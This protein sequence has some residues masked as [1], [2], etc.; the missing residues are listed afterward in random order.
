M[1]QGVKTDSATVELIK[2]LHG[3]GLSDVQIANQL[4][5]KRQAVNVYRAKMGLASLGRCQFSNSDKSEIKRLHAMG[6]HDAEIAKQMKRNYTS[7]N[8]CRISLGLPLNERNLI[9]EETAHKIASQ[10]LLGSPLAELASQHGVHY[11]VVLYSWKKYGIKSR[12]R[13]SLYH[14]YDKNFLDEINNESAYWLGFIMADGCNS[15]VVGLQVA[16]SGRD[17]EHLEKLKSF[18]KFSGPVYDYT[19]K[20][21]PVAK[22]QL[23]GQKFSEVLSKWGIVPRKSRVATAHNDLASNRHF[24]RGVVDGD[25]HINL[26]YTVLE[27]VGSENLM[28]QFADYVLSVI[29]FRPNVHA[30]KS[31]FRVRVY[32]KKAKR[33]VHHLYGNCEHYLNRKMDAAR[34]M[35]TNVVQDNMRHAII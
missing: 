2:K 23:G 19:V 32:S 35:L 18:A 8:G 5:L 20:G 11:T 34:S 24:W 31:I 28:N 14:S 10:H 9:Q 33:M 25:G 7:V 15:P 27:L 13:Q 16:L 4:G 26:K 3:N 29:G 22:L 21:K 30:M 12:N 6:M 17:R 1:A